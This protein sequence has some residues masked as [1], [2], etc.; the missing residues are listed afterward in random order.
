MITYTVCAA[1]PSHVRHA[2]TL[3]IPP[4][5]T[6]LRSPPR[7]SGRRAGI[8]PCSSSQEPTISCAAASS[9]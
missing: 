8:W 3:A 2:V 7:S 4:P 6:F 5:A 1:A 9:P